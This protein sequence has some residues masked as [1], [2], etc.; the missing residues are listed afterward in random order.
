MWWNENTSALVDRPYAEAKPRTGSQARRAAS[1]AIT[2]DKSPFHK[3]PGREPSAR[4]GQV[5]GPL[6]K[7][8][9]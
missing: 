4:T 6:D 1:Y 9:R 3:V 2:V 5:G 7:A 8:A